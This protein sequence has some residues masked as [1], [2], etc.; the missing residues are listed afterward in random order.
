M[1][2]DVDSGIW[3]AACLSRVTPPSSNTPCRAALEAWLAHRAPGL[4][5]LQL[6]D[7]LNTEQ[8][9]FDEATF[10]D[11]VE[12]RRTGRLLRFLLAYKP[13]S[14]MIGGAY[15]VDIGLDHLPIQLFVSFLAGKPIIRPAAG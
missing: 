14:G 9:Y 8:H 12:V 7:D 1:H 11:D 2:T 15:L 6:V 4:R 5:Q 3:E 10:A 13:R